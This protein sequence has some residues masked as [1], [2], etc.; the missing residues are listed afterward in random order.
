MSCSF[1]H[2]HHKQVLRFPIRQNSAIFKIFKMNTNVFWF[3]GFC[4][5][6]FAVL[7]CATQH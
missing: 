6:Q 2:K 7:V 4:L 3:D 1:N 5:E